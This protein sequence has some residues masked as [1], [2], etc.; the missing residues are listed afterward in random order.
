M[1]EKITQK[2][3]KPFKDIMSGETPSPK[4]FIQTR[5]SRHPGCVTVDFG[6]QMF[7]MSR[8]DAIQLGEALNSAAL[9][10]IHTVLRYEQD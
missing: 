10:D 1:S 2:M 6:A 5:P 8:A 3:H 4:T 9:D 7:V